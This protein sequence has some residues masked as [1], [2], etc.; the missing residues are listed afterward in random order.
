MRIITDVG[1]D[2]GLLIVVLAAGVILRR[3]TSSWRPLLVLLA[4]A[5]GAIELERL[6]KLIVARPA[7]SGMEGV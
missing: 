1:G 2:V 5:V 4:I 6:I 7:V 3:Q